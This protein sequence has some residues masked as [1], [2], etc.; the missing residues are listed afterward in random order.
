MTG[1]INRFV[2]KKLGKSWQLWK[3]RTLL[4][5]DFLLRMESLS[6][7]TLCLAELH[8]KG[9]LMRLKTRTAQFLKKEGLLWVNMLACTCLV[10]MN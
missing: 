7:W 10:C 3:V 2:R 5:G 8:S 1:I 9:F 6:N 4:K